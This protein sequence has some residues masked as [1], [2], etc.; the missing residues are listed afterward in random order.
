[1][2]PPRN[3]IN[4]KKKKNLS[5]LFVRLK[6]MTDFQIYSSHLLLVLISETTKVFPFMKIRLQRK[7]KGYI[8]HNMAVWFFKASKTI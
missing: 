4:I 8:K 6:E 3:S 1:M 7:I 2:Q 5:A